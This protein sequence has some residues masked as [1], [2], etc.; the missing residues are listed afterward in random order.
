MIGGGDGLAWKNLQ[1][2]ESVFKPAPAEYLTITARSNLILFTILAHQEDAINIVLYQD[3][4]RIWMINAQCS[5]SILQLIVLCVKEAHL[6]FN[7]Y[8]LHILECEFD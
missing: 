8:M 3:W 7:L 1:P 4:N 5:L 6:T 2:I